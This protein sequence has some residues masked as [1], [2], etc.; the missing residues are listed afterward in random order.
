MSDTDTDADTDDD[1][2]SPGVSQVWDSA[3]GESVMR[4]TFKVD[5]VALAEAM[6]RD[7]P[8]NLF[9]TMAMLC[10]CVPSLVNFGG[11]SA[12]VNIDDKPIADHH[13]TVEE[14]DLETLMGIVRRRG[15]RWVNLAV[16]LD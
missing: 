10:R 7:R 12:T 1:L 11:E 13:P 5:D 16:N 15:E 3:G 4:F 6:R 8:K 9:E 2:T 14:R